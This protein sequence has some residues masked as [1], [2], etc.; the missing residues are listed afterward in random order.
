MIKEDRRLYGE[1]STHI[2]AN[3]IDA[4]EGSLHD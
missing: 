2:G 1:D 4:D 3:G